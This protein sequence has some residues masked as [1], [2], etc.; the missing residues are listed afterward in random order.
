MGTMEG[1]GGSK[2]LPFSEEQKNISFSMKILTLWLDNGGKSVYYF[3]FFQIEQMLIQDISYVGVLSFIRWVAQSCLH[4]RHKCEWGIGLC[5][6]NDKLWLVSPSLNRSIS[7]EIYIT[8][9][10]FCPSK[11]IV[12][13]GFPP[14]HFL[15]LCVCFIFAQ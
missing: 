6:H 1:P 7:L 10:G 3:F 14:G 12:K 9:Q 5:A 13:A 15:Q 4:I 2:T 11:V 8:K